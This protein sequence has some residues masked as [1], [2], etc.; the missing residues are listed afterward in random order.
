[1]IKEGV[2]MD[3][4][5]VLECTLAT[6]TTAEV[7]NDAFTKRTGQREGIKLKIP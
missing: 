4:A 7:R 5:A 2:S 3:S 1:M 6:E